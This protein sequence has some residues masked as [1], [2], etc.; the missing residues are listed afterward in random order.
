VGAAT[1]ASD[2]LTAFGPETICLLLNDGRWLIGLDE[3][4]GRRERMR[5][6]GVVDCVLLVV[7]LI[8]H[9]QPVPHVI[10]EATQSPRGWTALM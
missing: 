10:G 7:F 3:G 9:A 2:V 5:I 8:A 6:E 1:Y 4:L